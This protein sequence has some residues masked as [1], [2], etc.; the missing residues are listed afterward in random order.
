MEAKGV[1]DRS[2]LK[3]EEVN[4]LSKSKDVGD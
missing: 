4:K 2:K 3:P 1:F